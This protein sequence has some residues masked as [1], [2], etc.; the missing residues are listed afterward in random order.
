MDMALETDM[1]PDVGE[2]LALVRDA[3]S[4]RCPELSDQATLLEARQRIES[5]SLPLP[6]VADD[7][8][9]LG[10]VHASDVRD[11]VAD[12]RDPDTTYAVDIARE[13]VPAVAPDT[14]LEEARTV[15]ADGAGW[16][17]PV[18]EDSKLAGMI[19]ENDIEAHDA[20]VA[21]LGPRAADVIGEISVNDLMYGGS[22]GAYTWAGLTALQCVREILAKNHRGAPTSILDLPCGHGRVLRYLKAA[23]PGAR[24]AACDIDEDGVAFCARVFGARPI[25]SRHDPSEVSIRE[26]FDLI[27]CGSLFTHL[28]ADRWPGF[29]ELFASALT[30]DGLAL[31][32]LNGYLPASMLRSL[33]L[34]AEE[35]ERLLSSFYEDL[36]G[37][38]E[39][40]GGGF[41]LSLA[42]PRWVL[43]QVE[44]SPLEL[45]SY[46]KAGWR[47]PRP[48]QH[49]A[50]CAL[51]R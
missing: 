4:V 42:R 24:L 28:S 34:S 51:R 29:L 22:R 40:A 13:A 5:T 41:G 50:V 10:I 48:A 26:R 3:M 37:Y 39:V 6:V 47:P 46:E 20:V 7:R 45:V 9:L 30:P 14:P 8:R 18:V 38:V 1:R 17:A 19:T 49:V 25:V 33:G 15:I 44:A 21:E 32:S 43:A 31:F 35:A 16:S 36:F 12:G 27:W 2:A 23:Y 11:A